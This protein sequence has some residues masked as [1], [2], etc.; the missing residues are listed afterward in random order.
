MTKKQDLRVL[1]TQKAIYTAFFNLLSLK[2]YTDITIQDI[3]DEAMINRSTFYAYFHDKDD[4]V[5]KIIEQKLES[6][7]AIMK[8]SVMT[9]ENE[10]K[11]MHIQMVLTQLLEQIKEDKDTYVLILSIVD[12]HILTDKFKNMVTDSYQDILSRLRIMESDMEVPV[13]LIIDYSLGIIFM[14]INWWLK[15]D[16]DYPE[17]QLARLITKLVGNANLTVLG[18]SVI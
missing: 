3:A 11:L 1:K 9:N 5:E 14:T 15:N 10:V 4:L 18:I 13:E 17:D 12:K 2:D 8:L 7:Q 6:I 16:C